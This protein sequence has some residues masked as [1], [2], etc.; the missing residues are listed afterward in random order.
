MKYLLGDSYEL[1]DE[2]G[3]DA[4]NEVDRYWAEPQGKESPLIWWKDNAHRF[5][6]L[7][8][9]ANRFLCRPSTSVPSERLFSAAGLTVTKNRSRLDANTLDELLFLNS[10]YKDQTFA[11]EKFPTKMEEGGTSGVSAVKEEN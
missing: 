5:S 6:H 11:G 1:S 7:Q 2:E 4:D 10:F 3:D 9:L 8:R